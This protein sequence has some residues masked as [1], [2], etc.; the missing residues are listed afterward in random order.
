VRGAGRRAFDSL[1]GLLAA[2]AAL[3][4]RPAL[5]GAALLGAWRNRLS[6]RWP[7][8]GEVAS[9]FPAL[10][11]AEA[12][13]LARRI[14]ALEAENRLLVEHVRR[15]GFARLR[16]LVRAPLAELAAL[17]PPLILGTFHVGAFQAL[18]PALERLP[19]P[20]LALRRGRLHDALPPLEVVSTEGDEQQRAAVFER[21]LDHLG[22]G[23]FVAAALDLP[24]GRGLAGD[25]LGRRLA[26]ARGPFALARLA[27]A[28]RAPIP[29]RAPIV[30]MA[31]MTPIV[32][33]IRIVP[34]IPTIPIIPI[35]GRWRGGE[36]EVALGRPL[37]PGAAGCA[38]PPAIDGIPAEES[39]LAA[40]AAR[41]LE[42]YLAASPAELGLG[43]LRELLASA[44]AVRPEE[45]TGST[46]SRGR[47][48]G[49]S[50]G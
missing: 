28:P 47:S 27:A 36:V 39:A 10:G 42:E 23:G 43:L 14:G 34:T 4:P 50:S 26:L 45:G 31:L 21:A 48:P 20:V 6:R 8:P 35:V 16:P 41:W 22:R 44:P 24:A 37:A 11:L 32:P 15:R 25:C 9:L 2:L 7:S 38:A 49:P 40:A 17:R 19:G 3:H 12:A 13:R 18:A 33:T 29:P 5:A 1:E 46:G 30:P